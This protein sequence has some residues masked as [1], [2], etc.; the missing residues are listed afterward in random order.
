[1]VD[2]LMTY[3]TRMNKSISLFIAVSLVSAPLTGLALPPVGGYVSRAEFVETVMDEKGHAIS[4]SNCFTDVTN[5]SFARA[6]CAAKRRRLVTGDPSGRFRPSD[7]IKFIEAAVVAVRAEGI[8][9]G[10]D[11]VWYRPYLDVIE[12]L[13][14]M[15]ASVRDPFAPITRDQAADLLDAVFNGNGSDDEED[16]DGDVRLSITSS[17]DSPEPGSRITFR[18]RITNQS[19]DDIDDV[20]LSAELDDD[21]EFVSSSDDAEDDDED[22][23]W[24]D[25]DVDEDESRTV[26]LNVEIDPKADDGDALTLRVEADGASITKRVTIDEDDD[27]DDAD[28]RVKVL[29]EDDSVEAGDEIEYEIRLENRGDEDVEATVRAY[30]DDHM[31]FVD[32]SDD[33]DKT[34]TTALWDSVD[35]DED[36]TKTLK[37]TVRAGQ[38]LRAEDVLTLRVEAAGEEDEE[39]VEIA[40][41]DDGDED[42]TVSIDST[43]SEVEPGDRIRYTITVSNEDDDD[44]VLD[45]RA[46]L[47]ADM[48]FDDASDDG[49]LDAHDEVLWEDIRVDGDDEVELELTVEVD[50]GADD[51]DTLRLRVEAGDDDATEAT[52][53]ED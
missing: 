30:L 53:V 38:G 28:I 40:D 16:D 36:E 2:E 39:E 25:I 5:Q 50:D 35:I 17:D 23:E 11:A 21:M 19:D 6:V 33:G 22:V 15:P 20:N 41:D 51:G 34:G 18:I 52:R 10:A 27:D 29:A 4:G 8:A 46:F 31:T 12:D 49:E 3:L 32:A 1:M 47:D 9:V 7:P 45:V 37:L 48:T 43:P 13:D 44:V 26:L 14:A 24:D 42:V